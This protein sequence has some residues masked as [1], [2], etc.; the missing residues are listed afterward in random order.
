[1][2]HRPLLLLFL[3]VPL[4]VPRMCSAQS[5]TWTRKND[6]AYNGWDG[7]RVGNSETA[8]SLG[9]RGYVFDKSGMLWAYDPTADGWTARSA[10]P[11][12]AAGSS[13]VSFCIGTKAYVCKVSA[14]TATWAF[15]P[16]SGT[17]AMKAAFPG[18]ARSGASAF[19]VDGKGYV[20]GGRGTSWS[21]DCWAYDPVADVWTQRASLPGP[22]ASAASFAAAGKGYVVGG[23]TSIGS[24]DLTYTNTTYEYDPIAD[25][26]TQRGSYPG[27]ARIRMVAFTIGTKGYVGCGVLGFSADRTLYA[28]D[29]T[30]HGWSHQGVFGDLTGRDAGFAFAIGSKGY[31][32]GG[33]YNGD[34]SMEYNDFWCFDPATTSFTPRQYLGGM[35]L[36]DCGA[37]S[38]GGTA[39]FT[40]GGRSN[41][42]VAK[43]CWSYAPATNAWSKRTDVALD[44]EG[45][46]IFTIHDKGYKVAGYRSTASSC[47]HEA[48]SYDPGTDSWSHIADLAH[49][50]GRSLA[51]GF[52]AAGKGYVGLGLGTG[53][54]KKNDIWQYDPATDAWTRKADFPGAARQQA[55]AFRIGDKVYVGTGLG[56]TR[57]RDM[58]EYDPATDTWTQKADFGGTARYGAVAFAIGGKGYIA[59][60][61]DGTLRN[62]L[63]EYDPVTDSWIRKADF[64]GAPRRQ[65]MAFVVGAKAYVGTGATSATTY[66]YDMWEYTPVDAAAAV[67]LSPR[68]FLDG[69]Y[70]SG[71][72]RMRDDLRAAGLVPLTEPYTALGYEHAT[73]GG[74]RTTSAVLSVTGNDA[75]VDWVVVELRHPSQPGLVVAS[76][77]ALLQRDGDIVGTDGTSPVTLSAPAGAYHV[78]VRHRNH[79]GAMTASPIQLTGTAV[80]VDLSLASTATYGTDARK[81]LGGRALLWAG[82]VH[83]DARIAYTGSRNDRDPILLAVGGSIPT[84]VISGTYASADV[85][86]D[87]TIKYT[88][89]NNDRDRILQSIGGSVPTFVRFEQLP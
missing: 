84:A 24:G 41:D 14:P 53:N 1:M 69:P 56:T 13:T 76:A 26:W 8:F 42:L 10:F 7:P 32:G 19:V 51:V 73:S 5:D 4:F 23:T 60:G 72:D 66:A 55:V 78:A 40:A 16:N 44:R 2:L 58:W 33:R 39:W 71:T 59:T 79:L 6:V 85:T 74:E 17:W 75:I 68:V 61:D 64:G 89:S 43:E 11:A 3:T 37:F 63:W 9:D 57:L 38:I 86:M 50:D 82:N 52:S 83:P 29:P 62:D 28:Y 36:R 21:S 20:A 70:D 15:D 80:P 54:V 87:G 31:I 22:R 81:V 46:A 45:S 12:G 27:G 67:R 47:D 65:A 30:T 35:D 49:A 88:G 25:T 18:Q 77:C 48:V 34:Y